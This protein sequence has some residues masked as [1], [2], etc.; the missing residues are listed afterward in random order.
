MLK[1]LARIIGDVEEGQAGKR[2][3]D[4][5]RRPRHTTLV[6]ALEDGRGGLVTGETVQGTAGNVEIRVGGGEDK[7]EDTSVDDTG[8]VGDAGNLGGDD[9]GRGAGTGL[10]LVVGKC[11]VGRV[12][13]HNHSDEE[14]TETV[15]EEDT[16]E[17][18]LDGLGDAAARVLGLAGGDTDEL[19]AEVGKGGVDHDGPE[20]EELAGGARHV[21]LGKGARV[22][23]VLESGGGLGAT[24]GGDD[25]AEE[26]D[27]DND[28]DLDGGEPELKL[29]KEL[30]AAKVVD[31]E[32]SHEEDGN[33]DTRVDLFGSDPF[34]D[35]E[36]GGGELVGGDNDVL[37]PV[38]P[39]ERETERRVAV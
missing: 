33:E 26:D 38:R 13:G 1:D 22:A 32:D 34:L 5:E 30:D 29:A 19:G 9:K 18:K 7:D 6:G 11:Q 16:V 39:A 20:T 37:E 24:S 14:H 31:A 8:K 2:S 25:D 3:A 28:K 23:P 12:V 36:G 27:A 21:H 15:E 35:N 4:N 17:G 10:V